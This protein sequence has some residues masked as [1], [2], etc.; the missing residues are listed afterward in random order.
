VQSQVQP[1]ACNPAKPSKSSKATK[2]KTHQMENFHISSNLIHQRTQFPPNLLIFP[3][4][5]RERE[6]AVCKWGDTTS[7]TSQLADILHSFPFAAIT[8]SS[9]TS[10]LLSSRTFK[11]IVTNPPPPPPPEKKNCQV[12]NFHVSSN[13]I[14]QESYFH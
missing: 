4:R 8:I 5:H 10:G 11:N 7:K 9:A 6:R 14:Y 3:E 12:E 13:L 2:K 1:L